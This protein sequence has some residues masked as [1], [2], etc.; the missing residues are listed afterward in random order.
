MKVPGSGRSARERHFLLATPFAVVLLALAAIAATYMAAVSSLDGAAKSRALSAI[1]AT[2]VVLAFA[3]LFMVRRLAPSKDPVQQANIEYSLDA[4]AAAGEFFAGALDRE[5]AFRLVAHRI[6]ELLVGCRSAG[7]YTLSLD[8]SA[9]ELSAADGP[10]ASHLRSCGVPPHVLRSFRSGFVEIADAAT[11]STRPTAA[12]PLFRED[13]PFGVLLLE[14]G[15]SANIDRPLLEAIATRVAPLILGSM[16]HER[17]RA[18]ALTDAVTSIPNE[19]ALRLVLENQIAESSRRGAARPLTVLA[20]DV[21]AFDDVNVR[22]GHAA[23]DR[24]LESV[25]KLVGE[26]LRQMDMLA[27]TSADEFLAVLPTASKEKS[28]EVIARIQT[29]FFG[30][31]FR[32]TEDESVEVELNIGWASFGIDGETADSLLTAARQRK[33]QA[34]SA[35]GNLVFFPQE[36]TV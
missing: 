18:N 29:A 30:R 1:V 32:I 11:S 36:I 23:G 25:A 19:R 15:L 10:D 33:L 20:I 5:D 21:R 8:G 35:A 2:F 16:S 27:R 14:F 31:K 9:L 26:N 22:Y 7:L 6:R 4:L 28:H 34:K 24:L 17:S 3:L 12:V 13:N